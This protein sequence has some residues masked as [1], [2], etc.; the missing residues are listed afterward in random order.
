MCLSTDTNNVI[1]KA[2]L[3]NRSKASLSFSYSQESGVIF[4]KK[5]LKIMHQNIYVTYD[6][7]SKS[8]SSADIYIDK[9]WLKNIAY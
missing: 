2:I 7:N 5:K 3:N 6:Q 1:S 8:N 9:H 4:H